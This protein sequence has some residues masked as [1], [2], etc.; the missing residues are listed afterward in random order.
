M[1]S[2]AGGASPPMTP[3]T[4]QPGAEPR[5][6]SGRVATFL[7]LA[8]LLTPPLFY[9][10][11]ELRCEQFTKF[12]ALGILALSIDLIWGY[13]GLLSLGHGLYFGLGAYAVGY[14]LKLQR[15]ALNAGLPFTSSPDMALPDFMEYSRLEA[16]P[17][18]IRPFIDI[19]FAIGV[20]ILL[21]A[22]VAALFGFVTFRLRIKGVY[23]SLITQALI[24]AMYL[25]VIRNQPQ[26][27]GEVGM[28]YLN[29]LTLFGYQFP[30][31]YQLYY[32]V[33]PIL[34]LC[35][36]G[37]A[38]LMAS[39]FGQ[40]L[41]AIRD[42]ENRVMA[43]GYDPA[44][45][46]TIIFSLSGALAGLAGALYV[47]GNR[48]IG[49]DVLRVDFSIIAVVWVAVG[50]RGTLSGAIIGVYL[51]GFTGTMINEEYPTLWK[52]LQ[53]AMFIGVVLFLPEGI[54]GLIRKTYAFLFSRF[55][56]PQPLG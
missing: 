2:D 41:T 53:G 33:A 34:I 12:A 54:V 18:W 51:V 11:D 17:E 45:Y 31:S 56:K 13:T 39:K 3:P 44:V 22:I 8:A 43:L 20:A 38:W 55:G 25:M 4:D 21:P 32:L 7:F 40:I 6:W 30:N 28:T 37:C 26:T 9:G 23:F 42:N 1:T 49:P 50:G 29:R 46:K 35:F 27:G 16:V 52:V 15:A 5:N 10:D 48:S 47:A 19:Y 36:L 14:S 24:L